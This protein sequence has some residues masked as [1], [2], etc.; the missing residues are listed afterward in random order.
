MKR[1]LLFIALSAALLFSNNTEAQIPGVSKVTQALP[2]V[3]LGLKLGANFNQITGSDFKQAYK[4]GVVGGAFLGVSKNKIGV[5]VEALVKSAKFDA[6][7]GGGYIKTLSLDIPV[8]FEYKLIP[9]IWL[10]LGP[11]FSKMLTAKDNNSNDIKK[12][13]NTT[14]FD[15]VIG[16]QVKLPLH[17]VVGA[18]YILGFSDMNN[19]SLPGSTDAW[20]NRSIQAY[21]GF[22]FL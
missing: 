16:L 18:R 2:K 7:T 17:L 21:L 6:S 22:R 14:D 13:F 20:K 11:Q 8:L 10:Q 19:K 15:G 3:D 9:R 4:P 1:S 12:Y 5:Q